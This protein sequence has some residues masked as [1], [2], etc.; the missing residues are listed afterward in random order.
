MG[1]RAGVAPRLGIRANLGQFALLTL[2]V[3]WVGSVIGVER[4]VVPILGTEEFHLTLYLAILS[5]VASFGF[6]K[7]FLNLVAGRAAD[8][9][10]RRRILIFGWLVAIPVPFL[11]ATAPNWDW[12]VIANALVGVNQGLAWTMSVTSQIDVAGPKAR[13]LAVGINEAAGYAGVTAGG[14]IGAALAIPYT[15]AHPFEFLLG[16]VVIALLV[17]LLFIRESRG[18]VR[19]EATEVLHSPSNGPRHDWWSA[20]ARTTWRDRNLFACSQAGL[21]EKFVDTVAWGLFPLF[22]LSRGL[23][24]SSIG[25]VVGAYTGTW[26]VLQMFTGAWSDRV[27]RKRLIVG[28]MEL[29]GAGVAVVALTTSLLGWVVGAAMAGLGMAMLYPN[30]IAAVSD[31][32]LPSERGTVL[33]VYRF[34]RDSGYGFG[35]IF[36][37]VVADA[38]G[39]T[40]AF[41]SVTLLMVVSGIIVAV[42]LRDDSRRAG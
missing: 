11:L 14:L 28:G 21:I 3:F 19:M 40:G 30:L 5:F 15:S 27:G 32:A 10:G 20:F 2:T 22:F 25:G 26:A 16:V 37:G 31:V 6:V 29:A 18:H 41:L 12:I 13:G 36:A 34:W 39:L 24:L 7:A 35:A 33:G 38:L 8:R 42:A 4:V 1:S 23:S 17:S 9:W